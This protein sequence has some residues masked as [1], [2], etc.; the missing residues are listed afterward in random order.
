MKDYIQCVIIDEVKEQSIGPKFSIQADEVT[1]ISNSEQLGLPLRCINNGKPTGRLVEYILYG[2]ISGQALC[3]DI[4]Q[5][6]D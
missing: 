3:D 5:N 6:C 4:Q 2:S 1:D